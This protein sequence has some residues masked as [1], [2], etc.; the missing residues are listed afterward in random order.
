[1]SSEIYNRAMIREQ[2]IWPSFL[3]GMPGN[4]STKAIIF[5]LYANTYLLGHNYLED[6]ETEELQRI[7]DV[8]DSNMSELD[9]NEQ[10]LVLE[11]ASKRYL[12][13]IEIQIK[14]NALITKTQQLNAGEQEYEAKLS[15]L[16]VDQA[17]LETK[18]TQIELARDRA[19][20]KNKDLEAR[21]Q[22][23]QLA[24]EYV[25]VEISQKQLE[26]G[27][28]DLKVLLAALRGI[29]IQLDIAN[30]SYRIVELEASKSGIEVDIAM[31]KVRTEENEFSSS[32]RSGTI[33]ER[34]LYN[35]EKDFDALGYEIKNSNLEKRKID[36]IEEREDTIEKEKIH[37][38]NTLIPK[39]AELKIEQISKRAEI[40]EAGMQT[41]AD[42]KTVSGDFVDQNTLAIIHKKDIATK[43]RDHQH[44]ITVMQNE[45]YPKKTSAAGTTKTAAIDAATTL[46]VADITNTLTHQIGSA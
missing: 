19:E 10:N 2:T 33:S 4:E 35:E 32:K 24:Q 39:E 30:T 12:K 8:Y 21:I 25:A 26:A 3:Y 44:E 40:Y 41:F 5:G 38:V 6:I 1:M 28:A 17:A 34:K 22:L 46:A 18:R 43:G 29:E 7:I 23:E 31:A 9:I 13:T 37:I 42:R 16:D 20:L 14:D 36:L 11:I 27:K 45:L 15:A